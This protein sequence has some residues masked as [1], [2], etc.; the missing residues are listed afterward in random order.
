LTGENELLRFQ[1]IFLGASFHPKPTGK[2]PSTHLLEEI[3]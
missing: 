1:I 3:N 2:K